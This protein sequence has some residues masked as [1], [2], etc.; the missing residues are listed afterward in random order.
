MTKPLRF[1]IVAGEKSGDILGADLIKALREHYPTAEFFGIGG[2]LMVALGCESLV[3]MQRLFVMGF[4]EP[5][6][7]LPELLKIKRDLQRR[8]IANPPAAFIGIDSPDFN[9]RL[10][11]S[12]KQH[13][14]RTI[15]YVSPSVWAYRAKRIFKIGRAVDLMLTLFPFETGIYQQH[16]I[17]VACVGH[18]LADQIGF[19][20]NRLAS[21]AQLGLAETDRVIALLPGSRAG[22]IKRLGPVFLE[23]AIESLQ[24]NPALKFIIPAAGVET[25]RQI[26]ELLHGSGILGVDQFQLTDDSQEA[27]SAADLVVMASGTATLEAMLLRRPMIVCYKLAAITW[28]IASRLV[29]IP[30]VA[31]PNLLA[32]KQLVPELMQHA[33]TVESL[34]REITRQLQGQ[35][36]DSEHH[37]AMMQEFDEIHRGLRMNASASAAAAIVKLL[38]SE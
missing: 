11:T 27:M 15:H 12:L 21:R 4:V 2:P 24:G 6:G 34:N 1:G 32:G 9:L 33:L 16:D 29:K 22:E 28:A 37:V 25:K 5:L 23:A 13:N 30:F 26:D 18:P 7:R 35:A 31:L 3:P 17:E 36:E 20:D 19:E 14:I 10:E 8:L 38:D